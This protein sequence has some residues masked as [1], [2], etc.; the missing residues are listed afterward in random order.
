MF[1]R[2]RKRRTAD[3]G[4]EGVSWPGLRVTPMV[5]GP[6]SDY[7]LELALGFDSVMLPVPLGTQF[8]SI[9]ARAGLLIVP[10]DETGIAYSIRSFDMHA[11]GQVDGQ[12]PGPASGREALRPA[13]AVLD[14]GVTL[15]DPP[16]GPWEDDFAVV[17]RLHLDERDFEDN[18]G[19]WMRLHR[20][21]GRFVRALRLLPMETEGRADARSMIERARFAE[22]PTGLE[23]RPVPDEGFAS[24][25]YE[26][27]APAGWR[28]SCP[29]DEGDEG[30]DAAMDDDGVPETFAFLGTTTGGT[31]ERA[32]AEF[33]VT[34]EPTRR[35]LTGDAVQGEIDRR[36]AATCRAMKKYGGGDIL[37][38]DD[39]S[40]LAASKTRPRGPNETYSRLY[41]AESVGPQSIVSSR[42]WLVNFA[43][44]ADDAE[45][46]QTIDQVEPCMRSAYF[47]HPCRIK[48]GA[49]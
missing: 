41:V 44:D 24:D 42:C 31:A 18:A 6:N 32:I 11:A 3:M 27:Q 29:R 1:W 15:A 5:I 12:A 43:A 23:S 28:Q 37:Y 47:F 16:S 34:S 4:L 39:N 25:K 7:M 40:Y 26:I 33:V 49:E 36:S 13:E 14:D 48:L 2:R 22:G 9:S 30:D 8:E 19:G 35:L 20:V 17:H 46:Q 10:P 38:R 21:D 45:W